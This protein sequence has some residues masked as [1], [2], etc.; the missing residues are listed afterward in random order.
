M[1]FGALAVVRTVAARPAEAA[2]ADVAFAVAQLH[3]AGA[4]WLCTV[5]C[6][7]SV[8]TA[9]PTPEE[10]PVTTLAAVASNEQASDC[11][12]DDGRWLWLWL[13]LSQLSLEAAL[14]D[15]F[16]W[17]PHPSVCAGRAGWAGTL[18]RAPAARVVTEPDHAPRCSMQSRV[19]NHPWPAAQALALQSAPFLTATLCRRTSVT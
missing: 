4:V 19:A 13:W 7:A 12:V 2:T 11:S 3:V 16:P 10:R 14:K 15:A 1:S 8:A 17:R 5:C 18:T 6:P 9:T